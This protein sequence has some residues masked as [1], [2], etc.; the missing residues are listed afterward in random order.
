MEVSD[1]S[2]GLVRCSPCSKKVSALSVRAK[3]GA[4]GSFSA[5]VRLGCRPRTRTPA[6]TEYWCLY[7]FVEGLGFR[8]QR[9]LVQKGLGFRVLDFECCGVSG[10]LWECRGVAAMGPFPSSGDIGR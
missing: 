10:Q 1:Y 8:V 4:N 7:C 9:D 3:E 2:Q 5:F 6:A